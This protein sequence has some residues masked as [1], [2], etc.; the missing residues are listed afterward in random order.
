VSDAICDWLCK[1]FAYIPVHDKDVPV[2]TKF[3]GIMTC[4]KPSGAVRIILNQFPAVMSSTKK[5][6]TALWLAGKCCW[7]T[8]TDWSDAYKHCSL[9]EKD[10]CLQW[11]RWLNMNF[12]ELCLIFGCVSSAGIFDR[13][14]I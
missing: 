3:S 14:A 5:W 8:K 11:F 13:I 2:N 7:I 10:L 6:L 12:C 9:R 1:G 4:P